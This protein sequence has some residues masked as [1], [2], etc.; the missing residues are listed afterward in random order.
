M[1]LSSF[2]LCPK[3]GKIRCEKRKRKNNKNAQHVYDANYSNPLICEW[4][5]M[6]WHEFGQR[7]VWR[8]AFNLLIILF[9]FHFSQKRF[10]YYFVGYFFVWRHS[11][12]TDCSW[13]VMMSQ[14]FGLS[15]AGDNKMEENCD[16]IT[17]LLPR[18]AN[19]SMNHTIRFVN[20]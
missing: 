16:A 19:K 15:H 6:A 2:F 1:E 17:T 12:D 9:F 20:W 5:G 10:R 8:N 18:L 7:S 4:Y 11:R 3:I 14:F 13:L